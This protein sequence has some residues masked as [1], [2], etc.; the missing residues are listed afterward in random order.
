M[1]IE[2]RKLPGLKIAL[3]AEAMRRR[4]APFLFAP[5]VESELRV[6][7]LKH[8][9]GKRCVIEYRLGDSS[10]MIG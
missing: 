6:Q 3:E 8:A 2:D 10:R 1:Q 9:P 5:V 4:L 7:L